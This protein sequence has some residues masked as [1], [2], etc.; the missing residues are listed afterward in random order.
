M[1]AKKK[2]ANDIE[3]QRNQSPIA[4]VLVD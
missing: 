3:T 4:W 1:H 2:L